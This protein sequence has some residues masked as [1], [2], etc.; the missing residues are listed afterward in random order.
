MKVLFNPWDIDALAAAGMLSKKGYEAVPAEIP[1]VE[2]E[3]TGIKYARTDQITASESQEY[4]LVRSLFDE[5]APSLV[6]TPV[7]DV[8]KST[9]MDYVLFEYKVLAVIILEMAFWQ[10]V[11]DKK[12]YEEKTFEDIESSFRLK[13][14]KNLVDMSISGIEDDQY[15]YPVNLIGDVPT[16]TP[17]PGETWMATMK[18]LATSFHTFS[19]ITPHNSTIIT[20]KVDPNHMKRLKIQYP[21]SN[22]RLVLTAGR[23]E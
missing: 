18:T 2:F 15:N 21:G 4:R 10:M 1:G 12:A 19:L 3:E 11:T 8:I 7:A 5:F 22:R 16:V 9:A 6:A 20:R 14:I 23:P 17:P 13:T